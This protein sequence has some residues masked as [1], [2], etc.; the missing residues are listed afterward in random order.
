MSNNYITLDYN[1]NEDESE[2]PIV[3]DDRG[4]ALLPLI[5]E[6]VSQ[7]I[8]QNS[9]NNTPKYAIEATPISLN[10][11]NNC[12]ININKN[13]NDAI[14]LFPKT[15]KKPWP[16]DFVKKQVL[17]YIIFGSCIINILIHT[18]YKIKNTLSLISD[19]V[20]I[21]FSI[22]HLIFLY[23]NI[24]MKNTLNFV[25]FFS[26]LMISGFFG[27]FGLSKS[28]SPFID[29]EDKDEETMIWLFI[30]ILILSSKVFIPIL[31]IL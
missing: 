28:L 16:K 11:N 4:P 25:L 1:I 23:T 20:G 3:S 21:I 6:D 10:D 8:N 14:D 9:Q 19:I 17:I 29:G 30:F 7:Q 31:I 24:E 15:R 12:E 22:I 2:K 13:T 26:M 18:I 27:G 5:P